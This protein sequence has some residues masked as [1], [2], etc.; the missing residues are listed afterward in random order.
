MQIGGPHASG[1][2]PLLLPMVGLA[3][4]LIGVSCHGH[5]MGPLDV[6]P[7]S[8]ILSDAGQV[9][10]SPGSDAVPVL[11][12]CYKNHN[13]P[14]VQIN[15]VAFLAAVPPGDWANQANTGLAAA[16]M[17]IAH[18]NGESPKPADIL[19]AQAFL[20]QAS[21]GGWDPH[22]G[23]GDPS[24]VTSLDIVQVAL[25]AGLGASPRALPQCEAVVDDL[26]SNRPLLVL[27]EGQAGNPYPSTHFARGPAQF[28]VLVGIDSQYAYLLDP[29]QPVALDACG[30]GCQGR[31]FDLWEFATAWAAHGNL[32]VRIAYAMK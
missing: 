22:Q 10:T 2:R 9:G 4:T 20:H 28:M 31:H 8:V 7:Q 24:G 16:A 1:R 26:N 23:N 21:A 6:T 11:C 27:V 29:G 30:Q 18:L 17:V 14:D 19:N 3:A 12:D 25:A 15:N 5:S 13:C 32:A